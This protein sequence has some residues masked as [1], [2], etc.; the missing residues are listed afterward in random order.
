MLKIQ[1]KNLHLSYIW[2]NLKILAAG[3]SEP[4][5]TS[6]AITE[7]IV[8]E[9]HGDAEPTVSMTRTVIG[10]SKFDFSHFHTFRTKRRTCNND[11][12]DLR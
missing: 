3:T 10:N 6:T 9:K 7:T 1:I 4:V 12:G 8:V 11:R 2:F 5:V